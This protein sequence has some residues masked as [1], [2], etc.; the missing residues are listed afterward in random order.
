[1]GGTP[2]NTI[3]P[4]QLI[5]HS[6]REEQFCCLFCPWTL[7]ARPHGSRPTPFTPH[8]CFPHCTSPYLPCHAVPHPTPCPAT[9]PTC[10]LAPFIAPCP[11]QH[12]PPQFPPPRTH[13]H[14]A[15][16]FRCCPAGTTR[17]RRFGGTHWANNIAGG[18]WTAGMTTP[19]PHADEP[20][21]TAG[22]SNGAAG[23][24]GVAPTVWMPF[25]C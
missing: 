8:R 1:M 23:G 10:L 2:W 12:F 3:H 24:S 4:E 13:G 7:A 15:H 20:G 17:Y 18:T 16:A 14:L 22:G 9:H 6:F 19:A 21:G 25:S 11:T 5:K